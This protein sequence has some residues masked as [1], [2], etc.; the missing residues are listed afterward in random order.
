MNKL[1]LMSPY[2]AVAK[3]RRFI[4]VGSLSC[5]TPKTSLINLSISS[6]SSNIW[7]AF[8]TFVYEVKSGASFESSKHLNTLAQRAK[9]FDSAVC[10]SNIL[11]MCRSIW[12]CSSRKCRRI[13]TASMRLPDLQSF[14]T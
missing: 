7:R 4:T 3:I 2:L 10:C 13:R 5:V 6:Q 9:L 14:S 8:A 11:Y 12:I 1:L